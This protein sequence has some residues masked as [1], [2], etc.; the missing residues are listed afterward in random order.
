M[1]IRKADAK[2]RITG[3]T[4]GA[5]YAFDRE[6]G[7]FAKVEVNL[8]NPEEPVTVKLRED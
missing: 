3:F 8:S 5:L 4:P 2:G 1:E 7:Y 6:K